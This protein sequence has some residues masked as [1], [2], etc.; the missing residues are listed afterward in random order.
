[1]STPS[2]AVAATSRGSF[3]SAPPALDLLEVAFRPWVQG[4]AR[5]DVLSV[6]QTSDRSMP[7]EPALAYLRSSTQPLLPAHGHRLGLACDVSIAAAAKR[8]LRAR[9]DPDGPRCRSF[10]S[11]SHYLYGLSRISE[12]GISLVAQSSG[13]MTVLQ[14]ARTT[15]HDR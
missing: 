5:P 4:H 11:A 2:S 15:A 14:D 1:L 6:D 3:E 8:L 13:D 12:D 7:F 9:I 10:P